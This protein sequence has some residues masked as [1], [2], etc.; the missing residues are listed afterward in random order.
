MTVKNHAVKLIFNETTEEYR[1]QI[2]SKNGKIICSSSEG[3]KNKLE[4]VYNMKSTSLSL[5]EYFDG[6][7]YKH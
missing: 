4:A 1:W 6:E 3:Y 2:R 7:I 5:L